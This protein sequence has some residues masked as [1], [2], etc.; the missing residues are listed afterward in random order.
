MVIMGVMGNFNQKWG[1]GGGGGPG[2]G[3]GGGGGGG[4]VG[5]IM[6]GMGNF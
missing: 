5:F 3:G 2:M 6:G 4:G 1:G